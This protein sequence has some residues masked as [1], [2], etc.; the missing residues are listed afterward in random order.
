MCAQIRTCRRSLRT[1]AGVQAQDVPSQS[2]PPLLPGRMRLRV[3][4]LPERVA[5]AGV[6]EGATR[7]RL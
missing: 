1:P 6:N 2:R 4:P 7:G 3:E 5:E